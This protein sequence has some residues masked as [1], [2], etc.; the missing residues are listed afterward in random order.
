M[1]QFNIVFIFLCATFVLSCDHYDYSESTFSDYIALKDSGIMERGWVPLFI[2]PSVTNIHERHNIDT[3][4]V[5]IKY[6]YSPSKPSF[7]MNSCL[8]IDSSQVVYT[9]NEPNRWWPRELNTEGS[10]EGTKCSFLFYQC[11][12]REFIAECPGQ[13]LAYYWRMPQ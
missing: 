10:K 11:S 5:W 3:N 9:K 6:S 12:E 4:E 8:K 7:E 2:S 1:N 13:A